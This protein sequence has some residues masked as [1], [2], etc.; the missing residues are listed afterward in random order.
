MKLKIN[1]VAGYAA[2][3]VVDIQTDKGGI[4]LDKFWRKRL[5]DAA[6]DECV[7]VDKPSKKPKNGESK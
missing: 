2:G 3:S 4:P 6:L 5:K 7:E 1:K